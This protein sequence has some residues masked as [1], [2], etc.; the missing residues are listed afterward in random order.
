MFKFIE[1]LP[2]DVMAIEARGKITHED[3]RDVLIP[4]TEAMMTN[5]PVRMLYVVGEDFTGFEPQA[6]WDDSVFGLRHLHGFSRIAVVTDHA[7]LSTMVSMFRPF[8]HGE[9]R[10][11]R[12]AELSAAKGWITSIS[13]QK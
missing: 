1:G 12:I 7:W 8:F 13:E 6:V 10:V 4:R 9:V 11:F 5:G 2:A 3:Y